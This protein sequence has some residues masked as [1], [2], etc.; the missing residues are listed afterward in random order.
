MPIHIAAR[1]GRLAAFEAI[2][3][4]GVLSRSRCDIYATQAAVPSGVADHHHGQQQGEPAAG[5]LRVLPRH[6]I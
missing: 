4:S 6:H 1:R 5:V 2:L 3:D